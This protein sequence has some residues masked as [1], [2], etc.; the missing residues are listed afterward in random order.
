MSLSREI[1]YYIS[2]LSVLVFTICLFIRGL[3]L[4]KRVEDQKWREQIKESME[5]IGNE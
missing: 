2:S 5:T 3:N 1:V 4:I